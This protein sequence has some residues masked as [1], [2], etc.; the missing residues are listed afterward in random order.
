[1][2]KLT[3]IQQEALLHRLGVPCAIQEVMECD[4][5]DFDKSEIED[6]CER[7]E[8]IIK[9]GA[10]C[11][12]SLRLSDIELVVLEDVIAGSTFLAGVAGA[13]PDELTANQINAY[14]RS[15][16]NLDSKLQSE[17]NLKVSFPTW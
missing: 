8:T 15:I 2:I 6:A 9:S 14:F 17:F 16:A 5:P 1:M 12:A 7:L 4:F 11:A 13:H 3:K 10:M